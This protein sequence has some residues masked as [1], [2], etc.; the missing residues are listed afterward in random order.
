MPRNKS[1]ARRTSEAGHVPKVL[2]ARQRVE[3][4]TPATGS[5]VGIASSLHR[6]EGGP[7]SSLS[8]GDILVLADSTNYFELEE[9]IFYAVVACPRCGNLIPVNPSQYF[10]AL[11]LMCGS[12]SCCCHFRIVDKIALLYLPVV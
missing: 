5:D 12:N 7:V 6:V 1:G 2:S 10:G 9:A 8:P 11:S 4:T 3:R